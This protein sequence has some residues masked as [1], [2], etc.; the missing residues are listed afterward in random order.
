[1]KKLLTGIILVLLCLVP[2][3]DD[4]LSPSVSKSTGT[5][6][7]ATSTATAV[8][9][10]TTMTAS[11]IVNTPAQSGL[12]LEH[13][14]AGH[15]T[16]DKPAGW[17]I[18]NAG[19]CGTFSFCIRDRAHPANQIFY[20]NEAGPVYLAGEQK[21]IDKNY[22]DMGGFP[23]QWFEMP[24][25]DPLTP[26]NFLV[27][28]HLLSRTEISRSFMSSVP[29]LSGIEIISVSEETPL[30][31]GG[32]TSTIRALFFQDGELGEGLFR[33]TVTPVLPLS[34]L[35][36]G[37]IGYA[38]C[39]TGITAATSDF[40]RYQPVLAECLDSLYISQD[41][42]DTCRK[43]QAQSFEA[44]LQ[45]GNTLSETSDIIM[46]VWENRSHSED[47]TSQ[48]RSDA[49]LG[50]GRV[51]NPDTGIVYSVDVG[52]YDY[53]DLHRDGYGMSGLQLLPD[54]NWELWTAPTVPGDE[55]R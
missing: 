27:N 12:K 7:S 25:V 20:F 11:M 1:M 13:Y 43:Q 47:I 26:V 3:C 21:E 15:F 30:M 55:I 37:G 44:L 2:G 10:P 34:G 42:I 45:A 6:P 14:D 35:P 23:V 51:Y 38:F 18:E 19:S 5:T 39:F 22:M 4:T 41:Y 29:E 40:S 33:L 53:Y 16:I 46:D 54:D 24:V 17:E 49:I 8:T 31:A 48:R 36:G 52:F 32:Q 50:T 9:A 28:F